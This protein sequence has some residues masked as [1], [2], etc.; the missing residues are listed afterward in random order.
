MYS[1][2]LSLTSTLRGGGWSAQR[3]GRFIPGKRDQYPWYGRLDGPQ[4]RYGLVRKK[5]LPPGFD[6]R[7]IQSVASRYTD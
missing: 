7:T 5:I 3:L 1:F 6:P 2:T 4:C